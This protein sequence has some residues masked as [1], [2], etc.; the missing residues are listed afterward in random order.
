[1]AI[2]HLTKRTVDALKTASKDVFVWDEELS[3]FGLKLTPSGRKTYVIQYRIPGLGRRGFAKRVTLGEHGVLTPEEARRLARREL[4]KVA[5]GSNPA[6][7]RAARR[8]A[9]TVSE[10]GERYLEDVSVT[11]KPSTAVEYRRL[12]DKHVVPALGSRQLA[13]VAQSDIRRLHRSLAKTPYLANRLV[14]MLGAFFTYAA[15]EGVG[16]PNNPAHGVEFFPEKGRERFLTP[17]EFGELGKALA[18]AESTGLPPAPNH[19]RKPK[20]RANAKHRPKNYE[21]PIP[22]NPFAVAAI[23][24]LTLTGCRESEILSLR[25]DAVDFDR[26]YL[27]LADTKTGKSNRPLSQSA[28]ALLESLPRIRGNP[29]VLPGTKPGK[30]LK[31]IKRIWYAVR[32]AA[33]LADV[34]LHDLRH[35]Y[36]SVPAASGESLLVVRSLLGHKRLATTERYAHLG[37]DPVKRAAERTSHSIAR[38]LDGDQSAT[39]AKDPL[40]RGSSRS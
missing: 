3:G 29:Y 31:E 7:D 4:G 38:W 36:A 22:A 17:K 5:Q 15:R 40:P 34:R 26:G 24:L 16:S 18:R 39:N 25:W 23:R 6:A 13:E 10:F 32:F 9:P 33:G 2:S 28:A 12:W 21:T 37:D 14:A 8:A 27:R 35:S 1:M 11:H 20:H 30:H 19:R